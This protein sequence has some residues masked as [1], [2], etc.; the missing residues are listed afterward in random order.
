WLQF[1][2]LF[3]GYFRCL[4][5]RSDTPHPTIA[6][7]HQLPARLPG[8]P[9]RIPLPKPCSWCAHSLHDGHWHVA[10]V[11]DAVE[12]RGRVNPDPHWRPR[13]HLG[14]I[15]VWFADHSVCYSVRCP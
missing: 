15:L 1:S 13:S 6:V 5:A 12:G 3:S 4:P 2:C 8:G 7:D 14:C 11:G 9:V 10:A